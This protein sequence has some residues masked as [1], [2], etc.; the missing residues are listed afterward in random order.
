VL[1]AAEG[2]GRGGEPAKRAGTIIKT[3]PTAV[4]PN[5]AVV[6]RLLA[7]LLPAH[8]PAFGTDDADGTGSPAIIHYIRGPLGLK[9]TQVAVNGDNV[10]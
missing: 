2:I 7:A 1:G 4:L 8:S 6:E 5:R 3:A 9:P 10:H